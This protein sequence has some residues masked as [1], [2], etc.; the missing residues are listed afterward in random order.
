[1]DDLEYVMSVALPELEQRMAA[2][3]NEYRQERD[4]GARGEFVGLY[5]K[6]RKLKTALWD[7]PIPP[8]G[9]REDLRTI[10]FEIAAHALLMTRDLDALPPESVE[11]DRVK[12]PHRGQIVSVGLDGFVSALRQTAP[13][14]K[15]SETCGEPVDLAD[16][17]NRV[18]C[19]R[20]PLHPG[21]CMPPI[22]AGVA[23]KEARSG[24]WMAASECI[25]PHQLGDEGWRPTTEGEHEH[26]VRHDHQT[27]PYCP[28][29]GCP[30][31]RART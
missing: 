26:F 30:W 24:V 19:D 7:S 10:A 21:V 31:E 8:Q 3:A 11:A 1:M 17:I 27:K 5:R 4:L 9:W 23:V 18:P 20:R 28:V 2:W 6:A 15:M 16:G 12:P 22:G 13:I 29:A 14:F 25:I